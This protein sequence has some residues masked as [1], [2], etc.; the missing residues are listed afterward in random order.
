MGAL[1]GA[2]EAA[3]PLPLV[4]VL[5][6]VGAAEAAKLLLREQSDGGSPILE[7]LLERAGTP[8]R[9]GS[10][11]ITNLQAPLCCL[12]ITARARA[13][14]S[15]LPPLPQIAGARTPGRA[16]P[17]AARRRSLPCP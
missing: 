2:A 12:P 9:P 10:E 7:Q 14:A 16:P 11:R 4:L 3:K 1:V 15:R 13:K 5:D 17:R 8:P 6:L